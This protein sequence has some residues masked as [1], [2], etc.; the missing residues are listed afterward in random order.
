MALGIPAVVSEVGANVVAVPDD[1]A[2]YTC[3]TEQD[4]YEKLELLLQNPGL[5]IQL[6]EAGRD[7]V[8][9]NYSIQA[10]QTTFLDL[11]T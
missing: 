1:I 5:R 4:W 8:K 6:G 2:G 7:W 11:F 9:Q 10:H 3:R